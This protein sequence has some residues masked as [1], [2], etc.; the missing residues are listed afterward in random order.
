MGSSGRHITILPVQV[1]MWKYSQS[2][3]ILAESILAYLL[4]STKAFTSTGFNFMFAVH[5]TFIRTCKSQTPA[6]IVMVLKG[7]HPL[8]NMKHSIV[9]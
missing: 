7:T 4:T 5:V 1:K 6:V 8:S 3:N 2:I 9:M